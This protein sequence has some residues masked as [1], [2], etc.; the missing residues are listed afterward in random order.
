MKRAELTA[1]RFVPDPFRM[2]KEEAYRTGDVV[3]HLW[4]GRIEFVGRG[5]S[6]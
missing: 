2:R 1:E 5:T 3:R 6:R 4:D